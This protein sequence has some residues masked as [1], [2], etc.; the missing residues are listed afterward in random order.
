MIKQEYDIGKKDFSVWSQQHWDVSHVTL[1]GK[2]TYEQFCQ[3]SYAFD[4]T[5][6]VLITIDK[7]YIGDNV[8]DNGNKRSLEE[9]ISLLVSEDGIKIP[10]LTKM[11]LNANDSTT[12]RIID[13][14]IY[15]EDLKTI[16]HKEKTPTMLVIPSFVERI[17][18]FAFCGCEDISQI[19]LGDGLKS[20]GKYAFAWV[21]NQKEIVIPDSVASLGVGAFYG[22][23][24]ERLKLPN[25]LQEISDECFLFNQ[26][27]ELVI[28]STVRRIGN[29]VFR[30]AFFDKV[31]IPEGVESIGFDA[32]EFLEEIELPSTLK[33]I[34]PDFY[35]EE[36]VDDSTHPPY[37][38]I[39]KNNPKYYTKDGTLYFKSN[40]QMALD[41]K[42]NGIVNN[43]N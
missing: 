2:P 17:G 30:G 29:E 6:F 14:E 11:V 36:V 38:T 1:T 22:C 32:F 18:N 42:Y 13:G 24:I 35:Y 3:V 5:R 23:N 9:S 27:E 41:S 26:I 15:T 20:I 25:Q 4:Y 34:A 10:P 8:Y 31:I 7:L 21:E 19:I 37:I 39:S 28:P 16:I 12:Y 43:D 33:E 40:N